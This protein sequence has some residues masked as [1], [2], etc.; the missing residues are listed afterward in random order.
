MLSES[1]QAASSP[2]SSRGRRLLRGALVGLGF[3]AVTV[4]SPARGEPTTER[5]SVVA[6]ASARP[7]SCAREGHIWHRVRAPRVA[8]ACDLQLR[9]SARL[10]ED[11]RAARALAEEAAQ[12]VPGHAAPVVLGARALLAL[13]DFE[14]A[15]RRF[16][17]AEK[18]DP[19]AMRTPLELLAGA[20]AA[21]QTGAHGAALERYRRLVPRARMLADGRERQ[22]AL[23]EAA[24]AAQVASPE[25]L[26]EARAYAVEVRREGSLYYAD[27]ARAVLALALDREGR[28]LEAVA[29]AGE[30]DG[31]WLLEWLFQRDP[32]PRGQSGELVPVWPPAEREALVA[33]LT[34]PV[35]AELAAKAWAE[36]LRQATRANAPRHLL[37][38]ARRRLTDHGVDPG[39]AA[40]ALEDVPEEGSPVGD[41]FEGSSPEAE[42]PPDGGSP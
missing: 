41:P 7:P 8:R 10:G 4:A 29:L 35:D 14:G 23:L 31:P 17:S 2:G 18:M 15:A 12:L 5:L 33:L 24:V 19:A 26:G 38:H 3:G 25:L 42:D 36:Y 11:P 6:A 40:D 30:L 27:L 1:E 13:G 37:D 9:A 28:H 20:R 34:E 21:A 22:R 16:A 32:A 39:N